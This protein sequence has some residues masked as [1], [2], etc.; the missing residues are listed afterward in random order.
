MARI[1]LGVVAVVVSAMVVLAACSGNAQNNS[2]SSGPADTL[3]VATDTPPDPW[4]PA[5]ATPQDVNMLYYQGP[6]EFLVNTDD[7]GK[8]V[9]G[10]ATSWESTPT[11]LTLHLRDGVKFS[12]G[13]TFDA[14]AVKANLEHQL[15]DGIP[16]NQAKFFNVKSMDVVSPTELK[17][18]LAH[19]TPQL[20]YN[21]SRQQGMMASPQ[22]L[23]NP[24]QLATE[25]V[26]TGP[27]LLDAATT[28]PNSKY[29]FKANPNYWNKS[30]QGVKTIEIYYI[31]DQQARANALLT[32]KVDYAALDFQFADQV[33]AAGMNVQDVPSFPYYLQIMDRNG[34]IIPAFKDKRV[35]LAMAYAID[36]KS[37]FD[38]TM[39]GYGVE[40]NQWTIP[41]QYGF[42]PDYK[43]LG[44]NL[45][46]AK[47]LMKEAGVS[48]LEFS[49]PSYG[50]F[51]AYNTAI[52]GFLAKIGIT[53]KL[54]PAETGN[55]A[56][57][58]ASG[59]YPAAIV[60]AHEVH[61][62][63]VYNTRI[64]VY[65]PANPFKVPSP[66]ID[67]VMQQVTGVSP[68]AD[69][70]AYQ[71]MAALASE[72]GII[73]PLGVVSC[74]QA[75]DPQRVTGVTKWWWTCGNTR[76]DGMKVN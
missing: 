28:V 46:K 61:P 53:M 8:L 31:P 25:P 6:Y 45:D 34:T 36:Q 68:A 1:R 32:H 72:D 47:E 30:A 11:S 39:N 35:R 44:Y 26:G 67:K 71:K 69:E 65:G 14:A 16:P 7:S 66:D 58:A 18:N 2:D 55:I 73:I 9:P 15:K 13:T 60:P 50:P 56:A 17:I 38:V 40:T 52:A 57:E 5:L 4:D 63:D 29:V 41:G 64:S 19:P 54:V 74:L 75:W 33:K 37:F 21:L 43:G 3:R 48:H 49:I 24:K 42:N 51:D 27:W 62:Q 12:D 76:F 10:L 20:I 59:K 70:P 23:K 22:A